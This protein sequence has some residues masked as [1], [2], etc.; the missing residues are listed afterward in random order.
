MNE[1]TPLAIDAGAG[2]LLDDAAIKTPSEWTEVVLQG[3]DG[4]FERAVREVTSA[5]AKP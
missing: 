2:K 1:G 4:M 3:P 5:T